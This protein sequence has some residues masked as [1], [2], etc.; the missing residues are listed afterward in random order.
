V[1]LHGKWRGPFFATKNP[2]LCICLYTLRNHGN[3]SGR[4]VYEQCL[5][6]W[7]QPL[8]GWPGPPATQR[9]PRS[10]VSAPEGHSSCTGLCVGLCVNPH[11]HIPRLPLSV[12]WV[13]PTGLCIL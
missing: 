4:S 5:A 13:P 8:C 9:S 11:V 6:L 12:H 3:R 10:P 1:A 2:A 7:Q